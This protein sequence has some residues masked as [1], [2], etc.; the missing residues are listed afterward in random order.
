MD[1]W[2]DQFASPE[3]SVDINDNLD[4]K[5][6]GHYEDSYVTESCQNANIED[7]KGTKNDREES[8]YHYTTLDID[9][10]RI[11]DEVVPETALGIQDPDNKIKRPRKWS[12][13]NRSS[14]QPRYVIFLTL[15]SLGCEQFKLNIFTAL[16]I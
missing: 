5:T 2:M 14:P 6:S 11:W 12:A 3:V 13:L 1:G 15:H 4:C 10:L 7:A 8:S 9:Q 16:M